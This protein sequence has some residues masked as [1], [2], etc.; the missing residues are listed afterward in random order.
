MSA[1]RR[2][3]MKRFFTPSR[4]RDGGAQRCPTSPTAFQHDCCASMQGARVAVLRAWTRAD[5]LGG[6]QVVSR[7][8]PAR[9]GRQRRHQGHGRAVPV[10]YYHKRRRRAPRTDWCRRSVASVA[11]TLAQG[12][13]RG[14]DPGGRSKR[15]RC[16]LGWRRRGVAKSGCGRAQ[17]A[18]GHDRRDRAL[19]WRAEDG[20]DAS[21]ARNVLA[22]PADLTLAARRA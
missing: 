11:A 18:S 1:R 7:R 15:R 4:A 20:D 3:S 12:S 2:T 19:G 22:G 17:L 5:D 6:L 8:L 13:R 10:Q 14:I 21:I 9:D 16:T